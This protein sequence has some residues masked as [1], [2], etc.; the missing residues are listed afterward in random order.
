MIGFPKYPGLLGI[1]MNP[2][3]PA[4]AGVPGAAMGSAVRPRMTPAPITTATPAYVAPQQQ[5]PQ[6]IM[7]YLSDPSNRQTLADM[8]NALAVGFSGMTMRGQGPMTQLAMA[9]LAESRR[10]RTSERE[11][12]QY[13]DYLVGQGVIDESQAAQLIKSPRLAAA[14]TQGAIGA[15][16]R[17][18]DK[19][20]ATMEKVML[21]KAADPNLSPMEVMDRVLASGG[22]T[23]NLGDRGKSAMYGA[24]GKLFAEQDSNQIQA[25]QKAVG[26]IKE[27]DQVYRVLDEGKPITGVLSDL[28]LNID[29]FMATFGNDPAAAQRATDTQ[30]LNALLGSDV[31]DAIAALGIGARGLDTPAEREFLRQVMTGTTSMT[32]DSIRRLTDIR[33]RTLV[34]AID[35]YNRNLEAGNYS[36]LEEMGLRNLKPIEA[37]VYT[38][39]QA[40]PKKATVSGNVVTLPNGEQKKLKTADEAQQYADRFNSRA[41]Q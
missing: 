20:S 10:R 39:A 7:G 19:L 33:R 41:T 21:L 4:P 11:T 8:A 22:T 40:Q 5:Q 1:G 13:V 6:G 25:A 36:Y 27:L 15:Q 34:R 18:P 32:E 30:L 12:K 35:Q 24:A 9:N 37:P 29:R 28:R 26:S 17:A 31:F 16:F 14:L 2:M 38:K 23:I 3:A